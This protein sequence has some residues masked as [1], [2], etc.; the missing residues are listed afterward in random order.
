V[1]VTTITIALGVAVSASDGAIT[2]VFVGVGSIATT[3]AGGLV[4]GRGTGVAVARATGM[5]SLVLSLDR[6]LPRSTPKQQIKST[7]SSPNPPHSSFRLVVIVYLP[8]AT[9]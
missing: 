2:S 4:G 5:V 6:A 9:R 1:A 3:V 7:A 8:I